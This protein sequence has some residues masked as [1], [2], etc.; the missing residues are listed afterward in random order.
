MGGGAGAD[1]YSVDIDTIYLFRR[2]I[3]SK[4]DLS[5]EEA[6]RNSDVVVCGACRM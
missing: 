5:A 6:V 2:G 4:T 1:I 3:L